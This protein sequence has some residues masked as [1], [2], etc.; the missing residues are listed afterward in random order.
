[1]SYAVLPPAQALILLL[2]AVG[3]LVYW[4]RAPFNKIYFQG[5]AALADTF[6]QPSEPSHEETKVEAL[7]V[8]HLL[9]DACLQT[10]V[11]TERMP[12]AGRT[13]RDL[14]LRSRT[15]AF[16]VG[17]E[18][19]GAQIINPD[20]DE[21]LLP[22]DQLLLLGSRAQLDAALQALAGS[23]VPASDPIQVSAKTEAEFQA[24]QPKAEA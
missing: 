5:K 1:L 23:L 11:L 12:G 21:T 6:N 8:T 7:R 4:L 9:K 14:E 22:Q 20:A 13:P 19:D 15:G 2:V 24:E 17:V 3:L 10:L 18:R 16:I